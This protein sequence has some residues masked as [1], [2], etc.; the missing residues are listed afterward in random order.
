MS[1]AVA[2]LRLLLTCEHGG[3]RVPAAC[4]ARF[5]GHHDVLTSHRGWDLGALVVARQ[6][7]RAFGVPLLAATVSR[8]VVD[9]NRSP[10]HP[11]VISELLGEL[12]ASE[13]ARLLTQLH[14]PHRHQVERA[15]ARLR[16]RGAEVLH[17]AVH[18]FTP[19]LDGVERRA[20]IGV[21]FDPSRRAEGAFHR[22]W[23]RGFAAAAPAWKVLANHPYRGTSDGLTTTLRR[24]FPRGYLGIELELNQRLFA[25]DRRTW[26]HVGARVV[27]AL[28]AALDDQG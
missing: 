5:R 22:R 17:I 21:L 28:A 14:R 3:H 11:R 16:Q 1:R 10:E 15:V 12:S 24:Q 9:L 19:V 20:D 8:L 23:K 2:P 4:A 27:Q 18:S 25:E 26:R 6:L 13:R 7:A